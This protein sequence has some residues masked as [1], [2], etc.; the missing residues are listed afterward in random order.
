MSRI[1]GYE[2]VKNILVGATFL[3]AGGGGALADG[4]EIL[5][6]LQRKH[7]EIKVELVDPKELSDI[8]Y[9]AVVAGMGSPKALAPIKNKLQ[10]ELVNVLGGLENLAFMSGRPIKAVLPVE[11]GAINSV[12]P[13]IC[14][15]EKG[16]PLIDADGSGRAVPGLD[17]LLFAV[18]DISPMPIVL[19]GESGDILFV[20]T[21]DPL[22]TKS[23]ERLCRQLCVCY[24][25]RIGIGGW[26]VQKADIFEKLVPNALT[27]AET[28]GKA[29]SAAKH[30]KV[31]P[32]QMLGEHMKIRE[33][34]VGQVV[35]NDQF[36]K[37]AHD[38]GKIEIK[39]ADTFTGKNYV[40]DVQNESILIRED[41]KVLLTCP[42]LI[43]AI[44][45]DTYTPLTNACVN[46]GMNVAIYGIPAPEIWFKSPKGISSW[47]PYFE[48]VGYK[49]G[50]V[51]F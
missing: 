27:Y 29:I 23:A 33:L 20:N 10:N 51:R 50:C 19:A 15:V 37:G 25:L 16:I 31:K 36:I 11:Y 7:G 5:D 18:N 8:D 22:D 48:N 1:L 46:T 40:I 43:C 44:D 12:T 38:L 13:V 32:I 49:G 34:C 21:A 24:D 17:V 26:F 2:D 6:D 42:D 39:G 9:A 47:G 4:L 41:D 3:G 14:A 28:V 35:C 45:L 30:E